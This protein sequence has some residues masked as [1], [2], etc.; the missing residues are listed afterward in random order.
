MHKHHFFQLFN[1][2]RICKQH[3]AAL[4]ETLVALLPILLLGSVC[5]EFARGYQVR[6][7]LILSLQEASRVAAV[8]HA[9]P[10]AWQPVLRDALSML[11]VPAGHHASPHARRDATCLAFRQTFHLP[12]WHAVALTSTPET[13]HLR[14]TYLHRPMQE[15]LRVLL[16]NIASLSAGLEHTAGSQRALEQEAWRLG[17]IP[18]V[19]EYQV[20]KHRSIP[21]PK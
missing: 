16:Q 18:I 10:H 20:L 9:A 1:T 15:W 3:G 21:L 2:R 12:C 13:I 14:L 5:V 7:L 6:H 19:V 17:L 11:F 8:H 4:A